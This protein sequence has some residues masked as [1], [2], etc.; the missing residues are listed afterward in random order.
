[1]SRVDKN[2]AVF[3]PVQA[4]AAAILRR[5]SSGYLTLADSRSGYPT[6][7]VQDRWVHSAYDP[8]EEGRAWAKAQL[9][10][11]QAGELAVVLGVGLLYHVEALCEMAPADARIAV[12]VPDVR[13][14]RDA[15]EARDWGAWA[16]KVRW[17]LG[18]AA[19]AAAALASEAAP[20]RFVTYAPA[21]GTHG[22][23]HGALE[24]AVR[25]L[26]AKRASGR[27]HVAVVGPI[28]GGSLPVAGYVVSALKQLG[29]RVTYVDHQ[30]HAASYHA[31]AAVAG[32]RHRHALQGHFGE[33]LSQWTMVRV[34]EDPPD[35]VLSLAQAPL[36]LAGLQQLKARGFVTAMWF[37][38]N[39]RHLTYWQQLAS[40]YD[41]WFVIQ[42]GACADALRAAGAKQV[43]YLPMA[44]DPAVHR[45]VALNE[46]EHRE[47]GSDVSFVGAGYANR[48]DL[49]PGWID[50][51]WSFKIWGNEWEGAERIQGLVQRQG[52]RIDTEICTKVFNASTINLNLHSH[53]GPGFDPQG[54]FV[55]PRTFE[56]A[57][58]RAFQLV[59]RRALMV[60]LFGREEM[61]SVDEPAG[62]PSAIRRWLQD[63]AGRRAVSDAAYQRTLAEHTYVHRVR[64]LLATLAVAQPDRIGSLLRGD[65]Q[66]DRLAQRASD[67]PEVVPLVRAAASRD[68]VELK[69]VA[70]QIRRKGAT[71]ALQREELLMLMLDEHRTEARDVA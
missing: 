24:A 9:A 15:C 63:D 13:E 6:A 16:G 27:L 64:S 18:S 59:D 28:Y 26:L 46:A 19:E 7:K 1:M 49:F 25:D 2:L 41:F 51:D 23:Y 71:T 42:R 61:V 30:V 55:N 40:G 56:L 60:D 53:T 68:R 70:E 39:Y 3:D 21:A 45:P 50:R 67:C 44:A 8:I 33:L 36:G 62:M 22:A 31:L 12:V 35:L 65:R 17:I 66:A 54:D 34:A 29:H 57:A 20:L 32:P 69:D 10:A 58:C 48:R 43:S 14:W 37:V 47:F 11:W 4:D 52:A 38:E 5:S